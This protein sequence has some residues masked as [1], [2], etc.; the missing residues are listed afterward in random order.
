MQL[1]HF[2]AL[3][4]DYC[5]YYTTRNG[6]KIKATLALGKGT[7][8]RPQVTTSSDIWHFF[9]PGSDDQISCSTARAGGSAKRN[10]YSLSK[11][12]GVACHVKF[13]LPPALLCFEF[14]VL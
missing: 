7:S 3:V 1:D 10:Y 5:L 12:E 13:R 2:F 4:T 9:R 6:S 14:L 8:E 11:A